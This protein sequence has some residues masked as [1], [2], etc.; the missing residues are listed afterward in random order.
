VRA[1]IG[2]LIAEEAEEVD[3][4]AGVRHQ[5]ICDNDGLAAHERHVMGRFEVLLATSVAA[6][7]GDAENDLR[8]RL[9][10]AAAIAAL[11][12][13]RSDDP[14][15]HAKPVGEDGLAQLDEAFAF[16]RGGIEALQERR[17]AKAS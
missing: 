7:L 5:L 10:A 11:M 15:E 3:H 6:D 2:D 14:A 1:W 4:R 13:L 9:V 8:P 12:A 16:L 17:A